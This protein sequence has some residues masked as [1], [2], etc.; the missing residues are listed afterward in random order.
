MTN[1]YLQQDGSAVLQESWFCFLDILGFKEILRANDHARISEF[2]EL[3][4]R[5]RTILE[6]SSEEEDYLGRNFHAL[7][8]FTDNIALGFPFDDDGEMESGM[9]FERVA[10]FQLEMVLSG[11]FIRGG[12]SVGEA[13]IDELA[14]YG[15]ALLEAY[16]GESELARDPRIVLTDSAKALVSRHLEYYGGGRHAPQNSDLKRDRDGQ[17]FVDY[18]LTTIINDSYETPLVHE[19]AI[20]AHRDIVTARLNEFRGSPRIWSKYEWVALYHN[21]FCQRYQAVLDTSFLIEIDAV[22]GQ[23]SSILET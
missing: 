14:V 15:P 5:G 17:W 12:I 22:R 20:R 23:I 2:H 19:E 9:V 10:E 11:F 13:Y 4:R 7:S 3:M 1:P 6:G 18:L 8:A 16:V 21:D